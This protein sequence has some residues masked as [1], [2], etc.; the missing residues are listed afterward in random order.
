MICFLALSGC[1]L[2][3][4]PAPCKAGRLIDT[5][6]RGTWNPHVISGWV[7]VLGSGSWWPISVLVRQ[8]DWGQGRIWRNLETRVFQDLW[9]ACWEMV[10]GEEGHLLQRNTRC[11][12]P[13]LFDAVLWRISDSFHLQWFQ[14]K[15]FPG[16]A[17]EANN[18]AVGEDTHSHR[19]PQSCVS[20]SLFA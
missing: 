17:G 15:P 1:G 8:K 4:P 7:L 6:W 18:T 3:L 13:V 12:F 9:R 16:I 10:K 19:D 5:G 14:E 20:S 11:P 2:S